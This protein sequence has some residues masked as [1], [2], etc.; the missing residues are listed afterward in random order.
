MDPNRTLMDWALALSIVYDT[1]YP[2]EWTGDDWCVSFTETVE[3]A[4]VMRDNVA[5]FEETARQIYALAEEACAPFSKYMEA[6]SSSADALYE[7]M[8]DAN[9]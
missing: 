4:I 1:G 6:A 2:A 8:N 5:D 7:E 9:E 3:V